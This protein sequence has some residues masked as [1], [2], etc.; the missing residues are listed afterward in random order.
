MNFVTT[1]SLNTKFINFFIALIALFFLNFILVY[2]LFY[3]K[4]IIDIIISFSC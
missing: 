1:L 3:T 4:I 2:F